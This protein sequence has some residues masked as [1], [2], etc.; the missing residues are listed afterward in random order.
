[1]AVRRPRIL[2]VDDDPRFCV[3]VSSLLG[4]ASLDA[5]QA[6]DANDAMASAQDRRPDAAI[7]DVE[8]PGV[9]GYGLCRELRNLYGS[10]LPIIFVSGSR[11]DAIDRAAGMLIGGDDYLVKPIDPDELLA[12][13]GRLLERSE[14]WTKPSVVDLTDR[15][16]EV[17]QLIA[18][19]LPPAEVAKRL[20]IAPKTVSSHVQRIL[21]KLNVHTRA[22]A[23][24]VAYESGL[25]RVL[26]TDPEVAARLALGLADDPGLAE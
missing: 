21:A 26:V 2:V 6:Y 3:F 10:E 1:M 22:Q 23:V 16:I 11:V 25:I 20:V 17:L 5:V 24:A 18:E 4:D 15:E 9:S 7:L 19:G 8:L 12:R 13:L 14:A